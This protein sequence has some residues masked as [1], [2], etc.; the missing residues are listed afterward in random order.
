MASDVYTLALLVVANVSFARFGWIVVGALRAFRNYRKAT[1]VRL[2]WRELVNW[3]EPPL[4]FAIT[5]FLFANRRTPAQVDL[6]ALLTVVSGA[7]LAAV[8]LALSVWSFLSLPT[9]SV[10]HY[11]LKE[12]SVVETGPYGWV[13]HPIYLGVFLIWLALALAFRSVATLLLTVVYVIP[14]YLVYIRSEEEM[15][16]GAYGAAYAD[17]YRRVGRLFPHLRGAGSHRLGL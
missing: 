13:R 7:V 8:G 2:G 3:A 17:Y 4:L 9:V 10:G 5:C 14:A 16:A 15:M 1:A 6:A 12:Q 11:V